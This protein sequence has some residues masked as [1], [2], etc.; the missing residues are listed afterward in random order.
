MRPRTIRVQL[1][2]AVT[3]V[4]AL[5][6]AL[7]GLAVV[8]YADHRDRADV[9]D[10]L[11]T[12]AAQVR[13]A[14]T[15]DGSLPTD[16][17]YV[18]RLLQGAEVRAERGS[19]AKFSIPVKDGYSTVSAEDGSHW[20]SWAEPLKTGAQ[21]QVLLP[22]RDLESRHSGNVRM[23]D[24]IV[25]LAAIVAAVGTWFVGGLVLRPLIRL[26]E[27]GQAAGQDG[28]AT[29][30]APGGAAAS[31]ISS[32]IPPHRS[33]GAATSLAPAD[34]AAPSA[35]ADTVAPSAPADASA[36]SAADTVTFPAAAAAPAASD[37]SEMS[38]TQ[39]VRNGAHHG[40]GAP[41]RQAEPPQ[42]VADPDLVALEAGALARQ[43]AAEYARAADQMRGPLAELGE[44]L[45]QLLD[46]PEMP[47]TQRH[48]YLASIQTE[49]RRMLA[50]VDD[51]ETRAASR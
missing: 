14:A 22:L 16:G 47:A 42:V 17:T 50:L 43:I 10:L 29:S 38:E 19:T 49:Y 46:N 5:V 8:L 18:V 37:I 20:R 4:V 45:D 24:L 26:A 27:N 21:M 41:A 51:L 32:G 30:P 28:V 15:R 9:D 7:A 48:L 13:T 34:A 2:L 12:R 11:T 3:A 44:G 6:V 33:A 25:V 39:R 1:T 23:I 31:P 36:S 35:A 40:L